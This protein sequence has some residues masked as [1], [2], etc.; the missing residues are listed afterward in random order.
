MATSI[1]P[2]TRAHMDAVWSEFIQ[3][4]A[5]G[6][7]IKD[8]CKDLGVTT[9]MY[10]V[11]LTE[12]GAARRAQW[13][14]AREASADAFMD[15]ALEEALANKTQFEAAHARTRIDTLKWAA[16]IRNPRA[17]S[18]KSQLDVN[19]KTLDLTRIITEA[20]ARL[21]AGRAP[22]TLEHAPVLALAHDAARQLEDLL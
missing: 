8:I 11:Y 4:V 18:D 20:N 1:G 2:N 22:V 14:D 5:A 12:G 13:D 9:G 16:R 7:L 19:V 3:R 6:D 21:A 17:Y 15:M 10:R